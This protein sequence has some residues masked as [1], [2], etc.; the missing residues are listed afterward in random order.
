MFLLQALDYIKVG[1]TDPNIRAGHRYALFQ[2]A[3]KIC[4]APSNKKLRR[5]WQEFSE[6]VMALV[7]EAPKVRES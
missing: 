5:R 7:A 4:H 2:R 6:D 1:L 3:Q